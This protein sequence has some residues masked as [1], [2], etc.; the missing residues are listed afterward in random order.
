MKNLFLLT[1]TLFTLTFTSCQK[2]GKKSQPAKTNQ[3][4]QLNVHNVDVIGFNSE[5]LKN[6]GVLVDVR[7]PAEYA[8]GHIPNAINIDWKNPNYFNSNINKLAKNKPVLI[9][10]RSGRRSGL[11]RDAMKKMG[12]TTIYNLNHGIL[13][14]NTAKMPIEK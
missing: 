11:A 2:K 1:L 8:Q 6:D 10:C 5:I 3:S 13:S 7:T 14:W 12:F 4:A 9:Y